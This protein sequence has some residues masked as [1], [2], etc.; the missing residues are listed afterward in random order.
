M[1]RPG[2]T[3]HAEWKALTG[4]CADET[5]QTFPDWPTARRNGLKTACL[6]GVRSVTILD[7][8]SIV[9]ADYD[10]STNQWR[11][12]A[13]HIGACDNYLEHEDR[14]CTGQLYARP[15]DIQVRC[16]L[17]QA[18]CGVQAPGIRQ[19]FAAMT[20]NDTQRPAMTTEGNL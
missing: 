4:G 15:Q 9:A 18:W 1:T 3:V 6:R 19:P 16:P 7:P 14:P 13:L 2:W 8:E 5:S 12:Y 17:C 20:S 10:R 11:Q